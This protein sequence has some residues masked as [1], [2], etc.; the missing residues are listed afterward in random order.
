MPRAVVKVRLSGRWGL[1]EIERELARGPIELELPEEVTGHC[2]LQSLGDRYGPR[3][4]GKA[5]K[6]N[7]ELRAEV[8]L[9]IGDD[10]VDDLAAPIAEKLRG[11]AEISIML[12]KPLIGG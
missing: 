4:R 10:Q 1:P 2:L 11:G 12:L 3:L 5:L 9:F 6:P 8:R 7:G